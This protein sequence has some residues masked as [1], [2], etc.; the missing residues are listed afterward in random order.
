MNR[1][2]SQSPRAFWP[3]P[4]HVVLT[5]RHVGSGNEIGCKYVEFVT[6]SSPEPFRSRG[7]QTYHYK[8]IWIFA[9]NH[10]A[11][12]ASQPAKLVPKYFL[13]PTDCSTYS[14]GKGQSS[15]RCQSALG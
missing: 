10:F 1:A 12:N 3:A 7:L 6:F 2:C 13:Q 9:V 5:K 14:V 8:K 4:R 15:G 11:M